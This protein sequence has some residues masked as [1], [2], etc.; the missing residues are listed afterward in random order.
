MCAWTGKAKPAKESLAI[1]DDQAFLEQVSQEKPEKEKESA[2]RSRAGGA[3]RTSSRA[4]PAKGGAAGGDLSSNAADFFGSL[5]KTGKVRSRPPGRHVV[6]PDP[7]RCRPRS[8]RPLPCMPPPLSGA[9]TRHTT[10]NDR[11]GKHSHNQTSNLACLP[12]LG[13]PRPKL[14]LE[15][16]DGWWVAAQKPATARAAAGGKA[17]KAG[18]KP[19]KTSS[20]SD[21]KDLF[22]AMAKKKKA[23]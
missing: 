12:V 20:A 6:K 16:T 2:T 15:L 18:G 8:V 7:N 23:K 22:A 21:A 13:T 3:S 1:T 5:Q 10:R 4:S 11:G 14:S 9:E 17:A 19:A